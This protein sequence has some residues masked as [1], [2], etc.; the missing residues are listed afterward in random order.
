MA[1]TMLD[2]PEE[3]VRLLV[4]A[5]QWEDSIMTSATC[6]RPD[7]IET[8][9]KPALE[10]TA[11]TILEEIKQLDSQWKERSDRIMFLRE[12]QR[13]KVNNLGDYD[14]KVINRS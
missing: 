9:V 3:T 7:L 8:E 1:Q 13:N 12:E 14:E 5:N 2:D 11:L 6:G 4:F 10:S